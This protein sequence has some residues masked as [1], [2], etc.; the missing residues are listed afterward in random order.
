[1]KRSKLNYWGLILIVS[2]FAFASCSDDDPI[3]N[4]PEPEKPPYYD[5]TCI[6]V[7]Q[8]NYT[9]ANGTIAYYRESDNKV[10]VNAFQKANDR[11]LGSIVESVAVHDTIALV[12]CNNSDKIEIIDVRSAKIYVDPIKGDDVVTPRYAV[13]NDKY[14]Y[15]SCWGK[16]ENY[17]Y[18]N[19]YLLKIDLNTKEIVKKI[20]CGD[21]AEGV[22][23][24]GN[25]LYV[26]VSGGIEVYDTSSD[27][28]TGSI[29]NKT[30][31]GSAKQMR[32]DKNNKMWY[33]VINYIESPQGIIVADLSTLTVEKEIL[34]EGF[35]GSHFCLN[36][37]KT[38]VYFYSY[39]NDE[40]WAQETSSVYTI[41]VT[42]KTISENPVFE[43]EYF[44]GLDVNPQSGLFYT[45]EVYGFTANSKVMLFN[46]SGTVSKE[47]TAGVGA[48]RFVFY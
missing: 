3:P 25:K 35:M 14:A 10:V 9:E 29:N 26:A 23:L 48:C 8:G 1:M 24:V 34:V 36:K 28:K 15:V 38:K 16:Y 37:D 46:E 31:Y 27:T 41:E 40:N 19:S 45:A 22:L 20:K 44:Y 30:M 11:Y 7:N 5:Y 17:T 18:P 47:F 21:E 2:L 6:V 33:S 39:T 42:T 32:I 4:P 13:M 43:G 12:M